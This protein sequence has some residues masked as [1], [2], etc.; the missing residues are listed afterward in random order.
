MVILVLPL[1]RKCK[2][3][4]RNA[5]RLSSSVSV[6]NL[7]RVCCSVWCSRNPSMCIFFSLEKVLST[8][9]FHT[10]GGSIYTIYNLQFAVAHEI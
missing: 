5:I 4:S 9:R 6:V 7:I 2:S 8:K 1:G 3:V 10:F